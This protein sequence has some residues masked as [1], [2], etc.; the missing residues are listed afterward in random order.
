M[1][2]S[3]DRLRATIEHLA[4]MDRPSASPGERRA[5]EW[6]AEQLTAAGADARIEVE[7][8]HGT[9]WVPLGLL[10]G[11]AALTGLLARTTPRGRGI[12]TVVGALCAAAIADD[13]SGGPHVFRRVLPRRQTYNVVA[14]TGDHDAKRT[15]VVVSH[16]DAARGGLIF[17]PLL[18]TWLADRF[19]AVYAR[20]PPAR[21]PWR[22]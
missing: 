20:R 2:L 18:L 17:T 9:Y 3:I 11:A 10:T 12:A 16:H 14:E 1:A 5:A 19:P 13:V 8:A 22:S 4:E 6:L 15:L 7:D 21:G